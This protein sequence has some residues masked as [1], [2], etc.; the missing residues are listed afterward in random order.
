MLF[1]DPMKPIREFE[2][3][4]AKTE[5]ELAEAGEAYAALELREWAVEQALR[6]LELR[7]EKD[8]GLDR[9]FYSARKFEAYVLHGEE[10]ALDGRA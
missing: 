10:H 2:E 7:G 5:E 3:A 8:A 1:V 4:C 9:V 6:F